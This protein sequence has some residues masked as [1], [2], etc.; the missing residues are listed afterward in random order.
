M[1]TRSVQ[2][3]A[4]A[5]TIAA[6][7]MLAGVGFVATAGAAAASS[8]AAKVAARQPQL[9]ARPNATTVPKAAAIPAHGEFDCNGFSPT[10]KSLRPDL[11]TDIRGN[12][13]VDNANT[14]GGRFY[15]NGHYIGHDEP[16]MTFLSSA[17]GS[18]NDVTWNETLPEDPAGTPGVS[19]PGHDIADWYE[20]SPAPWYS[21]AICDP[22]SYPQLS[23]VPESDANAPSCP[24][25]FNCPTNAYPGAGSAVMEMQF[26]PPGNPPFI[27]NESCSRTEWCA[28]ITI[29]S[30]ECT[31]LY[32]TCQPNCEEPINAAFI[33]MNGVPTGPAGPGDSDLNSAIPNSETLLMKP[34]DK[35]SVHMFDAAAPPVSGALGGNDA[36]EVAIDDATQ[37][38]SGFMQASA[39]NGFQYIDMSCNT[40]LANFQ[41]EYNTASTANI[42]PW[43]ALQTDISTEYETGHFEP[44]SSLSGEV[45]NPFDAN[46]T[47]GTYTKCSGAYE[48]DD[49]EGD[50]TSDELCYPANDPHTGYDGHG[51]S[52]T[53]AP[54]DNCQDN[55]VQNGDL[56]FDGT[57]YRTEWPT[58]STP[59][60]TYPSSF[61]ESEPSTNGKPYA[62]WFIQTDIALSESTCKAASGCTVPPSGSEVDQ[63]GHTAFYPYWSWV[64]TNGSCTL[65]FGNVSSGAGVNNIG[66]DTQYGTNEFPV[67]GYPEFEGPI[68]DNTCQP[69]VSQGYD[70]VGSDGSLVTAGDAPHLP[71]VHG[72]QGDIVGIEATPDGKGYFAVSNT[73]AVYVA[74]DADFYGD[75]TTHQPPL[76]VSNIVAIAPTSDGGGYYLVGSD[77]GVFCFG[78]AVYHGSLPGLKIHVSNVVGITAAAV[79]SG[80]LLVG[81]DGGVFAF[82]KA[83][84]HGS[85]P[86]I[87]V[88]VNN[89]RSILEAKSGSGYM[90]VG[91]DGGA[92]SFGTGAPYNGSLPG[93]GVKVDDIVGIALT[94]DDGGYW[95]A[96]S[97][98]VVYP[99]GDARSLANNFNKSDGPIS[100]IAGVNTSTFIS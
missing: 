66:K 98:G 20:L 24:R 56:D 55:V 51:T 96:G 68:Y 7:A 61:V 60:S 65:E 94:T 12:I 83:Q 19:D 48:G 77:G 15:D 30:L 41:P 95:M 50:E 13:G 62:Q 67:I 39:A 97:N 57:P 33:Q 52:I 18:G 75:L 38:T 9:V 47:G 40:A 6:L 45:A 43:A 8:P 71:L 92:F 37:H 35:I 88:R 70:L 82:G 100:G 63:P 76:K 64:D 59:T 79:G 3:L 85:L 81:S 10:E 53:G 46:D 74:G 31:N 78:D 5:K 44:C 2:R 80:Y 42:I 14:W 93:R 49:H 54:I 87:H 1:H 84:F 86:G 72:S 22:Y 34:G 58:G 36:F 90:L 21:M 16:D 28:S 89:V 11:C 23:C 73:G 27:D 69:S 17:S 29:D 99:F 26:Y 25:A 32:A 91:S 4:I